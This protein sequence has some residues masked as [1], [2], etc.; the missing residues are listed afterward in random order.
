MDLP[1]SSLAHSYEVLR[2]YRNMSS[3]TIFFVLKRILE[4][5]QSGTVFATAFGPGLTVESGLF[6]K[7]G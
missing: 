2:E 6:L 3:A 4:N 5:S 7:L 1:E